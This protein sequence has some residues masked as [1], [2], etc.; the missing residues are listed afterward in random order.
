MTHL[1]SCATLDVMAATKRKPVSVEE[2]L[3]L[4]LEW[5][6]NMAEIFDLIRED[7]EAHV[8]IMDENGEM[9]ALVVT[10]WPAP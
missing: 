10:E 9:R 3:D 4:M 1:A 7:Y 2:K 5:A 8:S 6:A